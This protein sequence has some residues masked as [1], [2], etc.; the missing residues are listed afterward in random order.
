MTNANVAQRYAA[1]LFEVAKEQNNVEAVEQE[2][3]AVTD[4]LNAHP[5]LVAILEHPG[6]SL[7]AKK[8]QITELFGGRVSTTVL[9]FLKVLFDARRQDALASVYSEFVRLSDAA[10]NR[11]KATVETAVP[12]T[13]DELNTL[14]NTLGAKGSV[15]VTTVVNP[16]LIGGARVRVGDRVYDYTVA[17]QLNRFRQTLKY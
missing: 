4:V 14:K 7:E 5:D 16:A 13:E 1:A 10:Q 15:E 6:I 9:N 11:V 17:G 8:Q 2:L 3:K 12:L